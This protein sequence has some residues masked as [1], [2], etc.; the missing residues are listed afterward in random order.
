MERRPCGS[1]E[2]SMSRRVS[3]R[4]KEELGTGD[5]GD[6]GSTEKYEEAI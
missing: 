5:K 6:G 3:Y 2:D 4:N 1:N